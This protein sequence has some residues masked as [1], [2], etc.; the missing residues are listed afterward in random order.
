MLKFRHGRVV[1]IRAFREPEQALEALGLAG[2]ATPANLD[3]V[4]SIYTI[5]L[6]SP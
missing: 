3:L 6:E 2:Q 1:C 5:G 4:R